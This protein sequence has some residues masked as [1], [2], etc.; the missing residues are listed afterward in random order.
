MKHK[1]YYEETAGAAVLELAGEYTPEEAHETFDILADLFKGKERQHLMIDLTNTRIMPGRE[2]RKALEVRGKAAEGRFLMAFV[3]TDPVGRMAAKFITSIM[4]RRD[5]TGFFK[6]RD[7]AS[8]WL[9][10]G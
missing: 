6:T 2:T 3:V 5:V 10:K 9:K 8:T 4:G 1:I 7:E